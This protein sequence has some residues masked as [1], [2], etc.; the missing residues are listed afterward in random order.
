M[1]VEGGGVNLG[2][3]GWGLAENTELQNKGWDDGF[4]PWSGG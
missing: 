3:P 2:V 4:D 1:K